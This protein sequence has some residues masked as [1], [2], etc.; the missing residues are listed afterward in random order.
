MVLI[1]SRI[2]II[3]SGI[4]IFSFECILSGI[5]LGIQRFKEHH[6]KLLARVLHLDNTVIGELE[7]HSAIERFDI[8]T[9]VTNAEVLVY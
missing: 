2:L 9:R 7:A 5:P 1:S 8:L 3:N 4:K 6:T